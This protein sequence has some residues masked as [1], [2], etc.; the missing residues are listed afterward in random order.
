[1]YG[2]HGH[3]LAGDAAAARRLYERARGALLATGGEP[4]QWATFMDLAYIDVYEAHSL[5]TLGDH[6]AAA[7]AF[8]AA[9]RGLR[10]G[11]HRDRGV[12][13][14]REARSRAALGEH[15]HAAEL[16]AQALLIGTETG[17]A[18]IFAELAT[19]TELATATKGRACQVATTNGG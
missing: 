7:D 12:Y 14:A 8:R 15:D 18:R 5:A 17:S 11:Y 9:I 2:A 16:A 10:P 19:V 6:A 13:L 4:A 3:A 1:V